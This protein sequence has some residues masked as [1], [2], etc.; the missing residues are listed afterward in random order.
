MVEAGAQA[1][2][3]LIATGCTPILGTD[4]LRALW[5]RGDRELAQRLYDLAGG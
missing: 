1:A 3:H 2:Q 5:R 4:T